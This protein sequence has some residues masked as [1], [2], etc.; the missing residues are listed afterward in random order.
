MSGK[1]GMKHY[2][3]DQIARLHH[4]KGL[5]LTYREIGAEMGL[6]RSQVMK[7]FERERRKERRIANGYIPKPKN[8]HGRVLSPEERIFELEREVELLRSFLRAAGRM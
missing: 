8:R 3:A 6:S 5:D 7:F 1:K 4:L 2:S